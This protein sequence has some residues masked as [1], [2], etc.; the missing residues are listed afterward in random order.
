MNSSKRP[1]EPLSKFS[2]M[3]HRRFFIA[4]ITTIVI[5]TGLSA[6]TSERKVMNNR[7]VVRRIYEEAINTGRLELLDQLISDA[8]E[9]PDGAQGK[10]AF[11][12][13]VAELRAGFPDIRFT[14]EDVIAEGDRVAVRWSWIATHRGTF[15]HIAPTGKRVTNSGIAIYQLEDGKVVRSWLETDRLGALQQMGAAPA[16][17]AALAR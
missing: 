17:P 5:V 12:T 8:Y 11:R 15:R 7:D 6:G 1:G 16:P 4:L 3:K 13:N 2:I 14:I 9:V 10:V